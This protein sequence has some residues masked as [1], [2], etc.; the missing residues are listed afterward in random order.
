MRTFRV[1]V[2][3]L[4]IA[5]LVAWFGWSVYA[6]MKWKQ[7]ANERGYLSEMSAGYLFGPSGVKDANGKDLRRVDLIDLVLAERLKEQK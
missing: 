2:A 6:G 1:V 7:N 3:T 4:L 5:T